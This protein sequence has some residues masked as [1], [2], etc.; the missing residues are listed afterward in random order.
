MTLLIKIMSDQDCADENNTKDFTLLTVPD[1]TEIRFNR[2]LLT[3]EATLTLGRSTFADNRKIPVTGNVYV[4]SVETKKLVAT[5]GAS[6]CWS[7]DEYDKRRSTPLLPPIP[8][9][10]WNDVPVLLSERI[11]DYLDNI[12]MLMPSELDGFDFT[13]DLDFEITNTSQR[14]IQAVFAMGGFISDFISNP[15]QSPRYQ[16]RVVKSLDFNKTA[17]DNGIATFK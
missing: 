7:S 13:V 3:N 15:C 5:Y 4:T 8:D 1:F 10:A 6:R 2:N 9:T 12:D 17:Y 16:L 14:A 11:K